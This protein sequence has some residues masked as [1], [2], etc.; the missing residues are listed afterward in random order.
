MADIPA[1]SRADKLEWMRK[2]IT[3]EKLAKVRALSGIACGAG[4]FTGQLALAWILRQPNVASALVGASRPEQVIENVKA[5]GIELSEDVLSDGSRILNSTARG[6]RL[7]GDHQSIAE[8]T[9]SKC[10]T[11]PEMRLE[12]CRS[13]GSSAVYG[14]ISGAILNRARRSH[15]S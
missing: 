11:M 9:A 13:D 4:D 7:R 15:P 8:E 1:D 10:R 3:E 14:Q 6:S 12:N 5:S 2:G